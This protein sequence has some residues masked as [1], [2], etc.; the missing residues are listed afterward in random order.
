MILIEL[1]GHHD[2]HYE[3]LELN[4]PAALFTDEAIVFANEDDYILFKMKYA[5]KLVWVTPDD[6]KRE[7]EENARLLKKYEE[8]S[9]ANGHALM[10]IST[11]PRGVQAVTT[12]IFQGPS[13]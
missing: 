1:I 2:D 8:E 13:V 12:P 10:T 6:A 4:A 5:G 3:W 7:R 9:A 11:R